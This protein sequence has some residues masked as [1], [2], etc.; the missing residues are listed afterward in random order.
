MDS[1]DSLMI[2]TPLRMAFVRIPAGEFLMGSDPVLD[3]EASEHEL[4]QHRV[5]LPDFFIGKYL[6]TNAQYA[7]FAALTGHRTPRAWSRGTCPAGQEEHPLAFMT[8]DD[9][10]AFCRWLARESGYKVRLPTEAEWEKAA[11]SADGRLYP[12]GNE[13]PD[14]TRCNYAWDPD[15][16]TTPVGQ[17]LAGASPYGVF[18]M[19]GNVYEWTHSAYMPYPYRADDG[20]EG[21]RPAMRVVR[22]GSVHCSYARY[23]RCAYRGMTIPND[24]DAYIGFRVVALTLPRRGKRLASLM[25]LGQRDRALIKPDGL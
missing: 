20:R 11:R 5:Y 3:S 17:Y 25:T 4:P 22:G 18:D 6:V 23:A 19:I 10:V 14:E 1:V 15:V 21:R 16:P 9:A 13:P 8:W 24:L 7:I 2:N 12:W